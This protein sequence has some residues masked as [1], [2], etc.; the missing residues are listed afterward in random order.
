MLKVIAFTAPQLTTVTP[1]VTAKASA[2]AAYQAAT[3]ALA[4]ELAVVATAAGVT[5]K[6]PILDI[7]DD[8]N[9]LIVQ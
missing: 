9:N 6:R 4:A 2:L 8:G 1:L 7:S 5:A 3:A